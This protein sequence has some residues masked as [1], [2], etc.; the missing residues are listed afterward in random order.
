MF[1]LKKT[2]ANL[3]DNIKGQMH[4]DAQSFA[5]GF[6]QKIEKHGPDVHIESRE[7]R[8]EEIDTNFDD[9]FDAMGDMFDNPGDLLDRVVGDLD[10]SVDDLD[11][12]IEEDFG[13]SLCPGCG[14]EHCQCGEVSAFDEE[15]SF[16][17]N[18]Q[19][20]VPTQV[21]GGEDWHRVRADLDLARRMAKTSQYSQDHIL[22]LI[23]PTKYT[24]PDQELESLEDVYVDIS[25]EENIDKISSKLD[26]FIRTAYY[27]TDDDHEGQL[28]Q[29]DRVRE[30]GPAP[31]NYQ[32][33]LKQV[34]ESHVQAMNRLEEHK[35][36]DNELMK[37][38]IPDGERSN[39]TR[40]VLK[41]SETRMIEKDANHTTHSVLDNIETRL[42]ALEKKLAGRREI[43]EGKSIEALLREDSDTKLESNS[44]SR[45]SE[46]RDEKIRLKN[47][48]SR[49]AD[50]DRHKDEF[51]DRVYEVIL[52]KDRNDE[53]TLKTAAIGGGIKGKETDLGLIPHKEG[54]EEGFL[55]EN[56][57]Q[58][59]DPRLFSSTEH[60]LSPD[61]W[62]SHEDRLRDEIDFEDSQ[63]TQHMQENNGSAIV[64]PPEGLAPHATGEQ[65]WGEDVDLAQKSKGDSRINNNTRSFMHPR[66]MFNI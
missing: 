39:P 16:M 30:N 20:L 10:E 56:N 60:Q 44:E 42:D 40:E 27:I 4:D 50:D 33:W 17:P 41:S 62:R 63:P 53:K 3:L 45:L 51:F 34:G 47:T 23:E 59:R 19:I 38:R 43:K 18:K 57:G 28:T 7:L 37:L 8:P 11:E 9:I 6:E 52:E 14:Q 1:N 5:R 15:E 26:Q 31:Y 65:I 35:S 66:E 22:T 12:A 32:K 46:K 29:D 36:P 54:P 61:T 24:L 25:S 55:E 49:L 2:T 64:A 48:E 13:E 58:D 21:S